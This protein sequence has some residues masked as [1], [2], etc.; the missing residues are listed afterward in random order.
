M[1]GAYMRFKDSWSNSMALLTPTRCF[2]KRRDVWGRITN[3]LKQE[4]KLEV[5][6]Y[7]T[8]QIFHTGAV[9][10]LCFTCFC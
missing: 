6:K 8:N 7:P 9:P 2:G 5:G 10:L 4:N 1:F 3:H